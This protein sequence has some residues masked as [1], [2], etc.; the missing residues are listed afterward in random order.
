MTSNTA[1]KTTINVHRACMFTTWNFNT[2]A[3]T[4]VELHH[5]I[6]LDRSD[7]WR[8]KHHSLSLF[9][10]CGYTKCLLRRM[11]GGCLLVF[12]LRSR[13]ATHHAAAA[14]LRRLVMLG[15]VFIIRRVE[16]WILR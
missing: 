2:N 8:A 4:P 16:S 10:S 5:H 13:C 1:R 15:Q 12:A 6:I 7:A 11:Q 14:T 3:K 9:K